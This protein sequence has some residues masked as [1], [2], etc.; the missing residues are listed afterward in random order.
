MFRLNT[1]RLG[2]FKLV[3]QQRM[4][5]GSSTQSITKYG[6]NMNTN[7]LPVPP[8]GKTNWINQ[9]SVTWTEKENENLEVWL[10]NT[11]QSL[12]EIKQHFEEHGYAVVKKIANT[13]AVEKY[14]QMV[15]D[16]EGEKYYTPGRHDLGS[17]QERTKKDSENVGQIMW[18]SD[19]IENAR[20]GPI[21]ERAYVITSYLLAKSNDFAFDFDMMI[22]KNPHTDTE[23]PWHQDE[24][25]WPAG[26]V[27]LLCSPITP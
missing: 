13:A 8:E 5:F 16:L 4:C 23:T 19:I 2:A 15:S 25:Y 6:W 17:H 3:H 22:W 21:H 10:Q 24:G 1:F 20:D 9:G 27:R 12:K 26:M 14:L 7:P 18:P 11:N